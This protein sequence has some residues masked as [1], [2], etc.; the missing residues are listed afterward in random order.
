[1]KNIYFPFRIIS[2][3]LFFFHKNA[4]FVMTIPGK[5]LYLII[6]IFNDDIIFTFSV[7]SEVSDQVMQAV[8][9][10]SQ[11]KSISLFKNKKMKKKSINGQSVFSEILP[12]KTFVCYLFWQQ[13]RRPV[14]KI[15]PDGDSYSMERTLQAGSMLA[16]APSMLR[17]D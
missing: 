1:V 15:Q 10:T 4:I 2:G 14:Y 13:D 6:L 8:Q 9:N 12:A 16:P 17:M 3:N 11:G 7:Y 5:I